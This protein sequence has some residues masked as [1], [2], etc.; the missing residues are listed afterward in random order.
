[1]GDLPAAF[2]RLWKAAEISSDSDVPAARAL[3][4][5]KPVI[6]PDLKEDTGYREG[7]PLAVGAFDLGGIR[8]LI[9]VP[10]VREGEHVGV[11]AIYNREVR[12]FTE[13][14]IEVVQNFA[15]QAVI[16]IDNARLLNELRQRTDD[17]TEALEQQTATSD[18]LRVISSSPTN[19]QPVFDAIA[20]SSVRLCDGQFSFV[21]RFDGKVMDFASCCGLSAEGL[22]AFHSI[23][24][25]P[26]S[27][28]TAA[29]RAIVRRAVV[30]ISDV[31]TDPSYGADRPRPRQSSELSKYCGC[32][33]TA[34]RQSNRGDRRC[35]C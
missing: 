32:T 13:K 15:A 2:L 16:A 17:L 28:D 6:V 20:E 31:E 8:A 25:M 1:M 34:R 14:Q 4:S 9:A 21:M 12:P 22:D 18:V 24:P 5:G 27:E 26:A 7:H 30:E 23:L 11:I 3:R 33:L 35:P 29:G 10:M 19:V